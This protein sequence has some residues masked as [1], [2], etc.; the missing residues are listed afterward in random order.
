MTDE[1]L[2]VCD[3]DDL[4]PGERVL[5]AVDDRPVCVCNVDGE[6]YAIE[7]ECAHRGGP[8]CSGEV[9]SAG[10]A[11]RRATGPVVTCPWHGWRYDLATGDHLG[12][13]DASLWT[14]AV[15]V[16]SGVVF[17]EV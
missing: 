1:R 2:R 9:E 13:A 7:H 16:E 5:V 8:I 4:P 14:P 10:D 11:D 3:A 12:A 6:Y 17:L 15:V